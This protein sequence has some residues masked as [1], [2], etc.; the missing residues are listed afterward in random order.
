MRVERETRYR[1]RGIAC[2]GKRFSYDGQA[3]HVVEVEEV[4][5]RSGR[6]GDVLTFETNCENCGQAF[7]FSKMK[8]YFRP[9]KQCRRCEG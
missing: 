8:S 2:P 7:H 3:Y 1:I 6:V 9:L 4:I 5:T